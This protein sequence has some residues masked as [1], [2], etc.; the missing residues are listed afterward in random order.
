MLVDRRVLDK[1]IQAA[2]ISRRET[3]CEAG[4]GKGILTAELCRRAQHVI[5][6]EVDKELYE[7]AQKALL[8]F[9][10]LTLV[11][12]D[13]FKVSAGPFFD[14]FI[15]NL[16][17]SRSRD[18]FEWL[19]TRKFE[20]G[21]VMVQAEFAKKLMAKPYDKDYRAISVLSSYCLRTEKLFEVARK[22]FEPQ[23]AV[24][25]VV[26]RINCIRVVTKE[27]INN[28]NLL[29]SVRNKKASTIAAKF[30]IKIREDF[31]DMKVD[32]LN[33]DK[34]IRMAESIQNVYTV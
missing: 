34:L 30:G 11:N 21:I 6:Y 26:I 24:E 15:S 2:S 3:I 20:R 14:I 8:Q 12:A 31:G 10:N 27:T 19:T 9:S 1:I 13:L 32:Q 23:P 7:K 22:S 25:S 4:T 17:Y 16:P 28:L 33:A 18:A 29:F 5:S